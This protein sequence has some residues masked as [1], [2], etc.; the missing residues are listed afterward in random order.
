MAYGTA[1]VAQVAFGAKDAQTVKAFEEAESYNGPSLIIA[2]SN[3]IA[4]GY[5]MADALDQHKRAVETGYWP[6]Y[7]FDPRK[8][9]TGESAL[10]LDSKAPTG[11]LAE[12]M[13]HETRFRTVQQQNPELYA[14]LL[15]KAEKDIKKRYAMYEKMAE[16]KIDLR[17][18]EGQSEAAE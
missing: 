15:V 9:G 11:S 7:R 12:Y 13:G 10:T 3:C 14:T 18:G 4:H 1:Y 16:F 5:D 6:L 2:Y 17:D 8:L